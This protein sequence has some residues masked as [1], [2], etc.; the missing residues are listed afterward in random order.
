[1]RPL[2]CFV[3]KVLLPVIGVPLLEVSCEKLLRAGASHVHI[4]TYHLADAVRDHA[5]SLDYPLTLHREGELL[6]TGGGI[7]NMAGNLDDAGLVLLLNGDIVSN[8]DYTA[9]VSF[10][11]ER[12]A[13]ITLA[14]TERGP[15]LNVECTPTGEV[16]SIGRVSGAPA[17][18][19]ETVLLGYTGAA[20]LSAEALEFFPRGQKSG[21]TDTLHRMIKHR[22]HSVAGF[23]ASR[24]QRGFA[25]GEIGNPESYIELHR[26]I[27]VDRI[28][29]DQLL[30]PPPLPF[31]AA[32][33]ADIA[34]DARWSGFLEVGP[35]AV[36][37]HDVHLENC[38]VLGGTRV[39]SGSS[40]RS[41]ILFPQGTMEMG[42]ERRK[43]RTSY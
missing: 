39:E 38:V 41:A 8:I 42:D 9:V 34:P 15:L 30:E 35:G 12:E 5:L 13:L 25:W 36:I 23:N 26:R 2:T 33:D 20:V 14:L 37:E 29:F 3:P 31:H 32:T 18:G 17:P 16:H 22:D 28:R 27:L 24:R 21:L 6:G 1:M 10:H 40:H 4:N 19:T 43:R 7:G 11:R